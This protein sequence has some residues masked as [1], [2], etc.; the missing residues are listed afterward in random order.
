[1]QVNGPEDGN[2]LGV[3]ILSQPQSPLPIANGDTDDQGLEDNAPITLDDPP[4]PLGV[5]LTVYRLLNMS[6]VF[7]FG[8]TKAILTYMGQSIAPTT[9]DWIAGVLLTMFLYYIGLYEPVCSER[10]EWFFQVDLV[11]AIGYGLLRFVGGVFGVLFALNGI[12]AITSL[13]GVPFFILA[14]FIPGVSLDIW[15]GVYICFTFCSHIF[16]MRTRRL[17]GLVR[18]RQYR[19]VTRLLKAYGLGAP[20]RERHEWFGTI[21]AILGFFC[22]IALVCVPL[23]VVYLSKGN[24]TSS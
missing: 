21:G 14:H 11:P 13:C 4:P 19:N 2:G 24:Q 15:L 10:W 20:L 3:S 16:W 5:K 7:V 8:T 17:R 18:A 6:V 1:M 22:G 9:L 23:G 12:L